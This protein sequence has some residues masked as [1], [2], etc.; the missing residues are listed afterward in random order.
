MTKT[1]LYIP[2]ENEGEY[3]KVPKSS[4]DGFDRIQITDNVGTMVMNGKTYL[5]FDE[6][7]LYIN[8]SKSELKKYE[9]ER[10][11]CIE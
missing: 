7:M 10:V 4:F 2:S 8:T 6:F 5:A 9:I 1:H 3:F 11:N